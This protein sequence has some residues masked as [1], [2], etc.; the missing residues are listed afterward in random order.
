M[1]EHF[2]EAAFWIALAKIIWIDIL[3]SGDNAVVIALAVRGLP[4]HQR[5]TG[6]FLGA[7]T[8]I[9]MR[10]VFAMFAIQLLQFPYLKLVGALLLVWIGIQ[11]LV[12]DE[13]G[14]GVQSS[15]NLWGAVRTILLADVAMS[16]DNVIAVAAAAHSGPP[17]SELPLLVIGL[18]LSIPLIV[19]GSQMLLTLM[20]RWPVIITLGAG[21][22]G[23]VAG[24]MMIGEPVV[25]PWV[26]GWPAAARVGFGLAV[27]AF[28]VF[29]GRAMA[30]RRE[31]ATDA[32]RT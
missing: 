15:G 4:E 3:L 11:L 31:A 32:A 5:R 20:N 10:V 8:A 17:G 6:V 1:F 19:V 30:R 29:A 14:D 16:L 18:A 13:G 21:L 27:A 26:E 7:G 28:V 24:E 22:L 9:V 23:Y 2:G 12:P 25:K